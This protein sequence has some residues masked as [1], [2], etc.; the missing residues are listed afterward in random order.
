MHK[1]CEWDKKPKL[2]SVDPKTK[3]EKYQTKAPKCCYTIPV[4]YRGLFRTDDIEHMLE[5]L[6][7]N[8]SYAV[9]E[10]MNPE[11]IIIYHTSSGRLFKKT[12]SNDE[13]PKEQNDS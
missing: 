7:D 6:K 13:K 2:V 11:G 12:I 3:E 4:L 8:G 9:P 1:W 10:F 5:E